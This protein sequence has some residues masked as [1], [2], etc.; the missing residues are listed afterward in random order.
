MAI[1]L[2]S[3]N[4]TTIVGL[5]NAIFGIAPGYIYL[6]NFSAYASQ[7]GVEATA[8]ALAELLGQTNTEF[9]A[10]MVANLGL[11]GDAAT[12]A[13]AYFDSRFAAGASQGDV[14]REAV[15]YLLT[16]A[17]QADATYGSVATSFNATVVRSEIYSTDSSNAVTDAA[18]L[19]Q[20]AAGT[21]PQSKAFSANDDALSGGA[22]DDTF[23]SSTAANYAA[24]R[25][26][27]DGGEGSD[28]VALT[29][30]AGGLT[31]Q[32][33]TSIEKLQLIMT[34]GTAGAAATNTVSM[35]KAT[36][37]EE[38]EILNFTGST[39]G[40]EDTVALT[41]LAAGQKVK[42]TDGDGEFIVTAALKDATGT[43]DSITLTLDDASADSVTI[44]DIET[45]NIVSSGTG[46][47]GNAINTQGL[48]MD[49]MTTLNVT[50]TAKVNL[51]AVSDTGKAI[52]INAADNSGGVTASFT[53]TP[54]ADTKAFTLTGSSGDDTFTFVGQDIDGDTGTT[55]Y[56][57]VDFGDGNDTVAFSDAVSTVEA[58]LKKGLTSFTGYENV[59][60]NAAETAVDLNAAGFHG[61][62]IQLGNA[63]IELVNI[64]SGSVIDQKI[65][66]TTLEGTMYGAGAKSLTI[67]TNGLALTLQGDG[68][69]NDANTFVGV[70]NLTI[71]NT[72]STA[73]TV[74]V[75]DLNEY[76]GSNLTLTGNGAITVANGLDNNTVTIDAS[77][78]EKALTLT[79]G[80]A[81]TLITS[82]AGADVLTISAVSAVDEVST[83]AGD[84]Q[85]DLAQDNGANS[86]FTHT[87]LD[88][89]DMGAG[90]KDKL[91]LMGDQ[92][93]SVVTDLTSATLTGIEL[94]DA[95]QAITGK[96]HEVKLSAAQS[97]NFAGTS[98]VASSDLSAGTGA[99]A[100]TITVTVA[101]TDS[102]ASGT[103]LVDTFTIAAGHGG[104]T[105]NGL[106]AN[107]VVDLTAFDPDSNDWT[108]AVASKDAV[109]AQGEWY[110]TDAT[111]TLTIY[112]NSDASVVDI[113]LTGVKTVALNGGETATIS[114][115]DA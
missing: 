17:A 22:G 37:V 78:M 105:I 109:D 107:D 42:I 30:T 88:V 45:V 62:G 33:F 59:R 92:N 41:N 23:S 50:G 10:T 113:V 52:T 76:A 83:G 90:T 58:N 51:G 114:A 65:A 72:K 4:N 54:L 14:A 103:A 87:V 32:G 71:D 73:A 99:V 25:D 48:S 115:L 97:V 8:N 84:D 108:T 19:A 40:Q 1:G 11:S 28:T 102:T 13:E 64:K 86:D 110:F 21:V 63:S 46:S 112:D 20:A 98:A 16:P 91:R 69:V 100:A 38:I 89:I 75:T 96:T 27:V 26:T 3:S 60:F 47:S 29:M 95:S 55:R 67:N 15:N 77:A 5:S 93:D 82:G 18:V 35:A 34:D 2:L 44:N 36:D 61:L 85:V 111:D 43:S 53:Q 79:T 57:S 66:V 101:K 106:K 24:T 81:G 70:N 9:K 56:Y 49:A 7:N 80:T 68:G 12:A 39:T 74:T 6:N 104:V 94:L 31:P